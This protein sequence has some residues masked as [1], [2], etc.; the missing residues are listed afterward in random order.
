M[1]E[2][3]SSAIEQFHQAND[4]YQKEKYP[5]AIGRYL[6]LVQKGYRDP[7]I[8]Y[9]LGNAY[10]KKGELGR[11]ILFYEKARM[12]LPRDDDIQKNLAYANSL[13]IDK[14][15]T[16]S[17]GLF[18]LWERV[19]DFLTL[20]ELTMIFT[21]IYLVLIFWGFSSFGKK[22]RLSGRGCFSF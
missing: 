7:Y 10:F 2:E 14:I 4:Y 5:E 17:S 12:L 21:G 20:N 9:N 18:S 16:K 22:R 15:E 13:A 6:D 11:A 1:G 3:R 19:T 8:F